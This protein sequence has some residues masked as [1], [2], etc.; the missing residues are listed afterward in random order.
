MITEKDV[1]EALDQLV[2]ALLELAKI[3]D[4][5]LNKLTTWRNTKRAPGKPIRSRRESKRRNLSI[6]K[7][8]GPT[9]WPG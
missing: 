4:S 6:M 3:E 9:A 5:K 8:S 2:E 7:L 1:N